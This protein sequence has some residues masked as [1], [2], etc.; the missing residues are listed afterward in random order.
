MKKA[1]YELDTLQSMETGLQKDGTG[2]TGKQ[3]D[4]RGRSVYFLHDLIHFRGSAEGKLA[5]CSCCGAG[6]QSIFCIPV[7]MYPIQGL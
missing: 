3:T 5:I 2:G 1:N 4:L 6:K 7:W